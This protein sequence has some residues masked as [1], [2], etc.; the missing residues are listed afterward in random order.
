MAFERKETQ[1]GR[2]AYLGRGIFGRCFDGARWQWAP[3]PYAS[4]EPGRLTRHSR[5]WATHGMSEERYPQLLARASGE[6]GLFWLGGGRWSEPLLVFHDA[7]PYN[8]IA[9]PSARR[10]QD[11]RSGGRGP[12]QTP[13]CNQLSLALDPRSGSLWM[14]Y[15][16]PKRRHITDADLGDQS[17]PTGQVQAR[18]AGFGA[19]IVCHWVDLE[20]RQYRLPRVVE[21]E[22]PV[23]PPGEPFPTTT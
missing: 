1:G 22:K 17:Q 6:L 7:V 21:E 16:V 9:L 15:E 4:G 18:P 14:A 11:L 23:P 10:G 8:A 20:E 3:S 12:Y 13:L 5:F 19:D 2:F